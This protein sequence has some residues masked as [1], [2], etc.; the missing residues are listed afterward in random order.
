M[1]L[2]T[3]RKRRLLIVSNRLPVTVSVKSGLLSL[4]WS[5]GVLASGIGSYLEA[6]TQRG[7]EAIW[8]GWPGAEIPAAHEEEVRSVLA[9][10][11]GAV[12]VFVDGE[13]MS[14]FYEG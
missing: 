5:A 8:I 11:H 4:H 14:S 9:R 12:P 13:T 2:A 6:V 7:D 10:D 1:K 3:I